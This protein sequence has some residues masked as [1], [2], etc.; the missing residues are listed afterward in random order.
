MVPI[1][2]RLDDRYWV[3]GKL[4]SWVLLFF[5]LR[6][7]ELN[8]ERVSLIAT[9]FVV[10]NQCFE[11]SHNYLFFFFTKSVLFDSGRFRFVYYVNHILH[12]IDLP[13]LLSEQ[14][15]KYLINQESHKEK[16]SFNLQIVHFYAWTPICRIY[17]MQWAKLQSILQV[18]VNKSFWSFWFKLKSAFECLDSIFNALIL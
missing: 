2:L 15:P 1:W 13:L 5:L 12:G 11:I 8:R 6:I 16:P 10:I 9:G 14:Y 18:V 3:I 4:Y 7:H 17:Q